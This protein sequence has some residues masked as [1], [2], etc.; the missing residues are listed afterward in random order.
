ML[1]AFSNNIADTYGTYK[2][3]AHDIVVIADKNGI[4]LGGAIPYLKDEN[5]YRFFPREKVK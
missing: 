3:S 5:L 1:Q 2:Y 4:F